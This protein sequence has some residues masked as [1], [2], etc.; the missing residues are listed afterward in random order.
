[1]ILANTDDKEI[2][3]ITIAT[4]NILTHRKKKG[5]DFTHFHLFSSNNWGFIIYDEVHLLRADLSNDQWATGKKT[6]GTHGHPGSWRRSWRRRIF[7]DWTKKVRRALEGSRENMIA[8]AQCIEVRVPMRSIMRSL[9]SVSDDR[10]KFRISS[11]N[12][13]KMRVI[14]TLLFKHQGPS[15]DCWSIPDQ[16]R[17]VS[18]RFNIPL[19]TGKTAL[20][21]RQKLYEAFRHKRIPALV[22]S[23]VANFSIDCPMPICDSN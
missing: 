6:S 7:T 8:E 13:E 12:P 3:P 19:I 5:G 21:D 16:L 1:M 4:Y 9:Y 17:K 18:T 23:K 20:Q 22:V 14:G 10:E 15:L 2:K 11:E